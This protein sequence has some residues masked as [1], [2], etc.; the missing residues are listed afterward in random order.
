MVRHLFEV[1]SGIDSQMVGE[2][3]ILGQVKSLRMP[4]TKHLRQNAK[5][6]LPKGFQAAK[7]RGLIL[8]YPRAGKFRYVCELARRIL[9]S[10]NLTAS[11]NR[12]KVGISHGG[13]QIEGSQAITVTGR[14]FDYVFS[15]E[16]NRS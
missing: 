15:A 11:G 9:V 12:Q 13:F 6:S 3:E 1:T 10:F 8:E 16:E 4:V 2:T 7:W 14:T 5:S